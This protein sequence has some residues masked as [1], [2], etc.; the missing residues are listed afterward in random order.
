MT[1]SEVLQFHNAS[2]TESPGERHDDASPLPI[3]RLSNNAARAPNRLIE[4]E[5]LRVQ[6]HTP[7]TSSLRTRSS[8]TTGI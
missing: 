1:E 3:L 7:K 6:E 4:A 2:A 5:E 8:L